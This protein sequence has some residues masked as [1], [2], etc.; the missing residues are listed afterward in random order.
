MCST[1]CSTCVWMESGIRNQESFIFRNQESFI[2]GAGR[3]LWGVVLRQV[4][5]GR[6]SQSFFS[7]SHGIESPFRG[8]DSIVKEAVPWRRNHQDQCIINHA[9]TQIGTLNCCVALKFDRHIGSTAA[10]V[11]VKFQSDRTILNTNLADSILYEILR[12][13][14]FSDIETG[15]WLLSRNCLSRDLE[16]ERHTENLDGGEFVRN[17]DL[18]LAEWQ[19]WGQPYL[20][21]EQDRCCLRHGSRRSRRP[22]ILHGSH[23][24][25]FLTAGCVTRVWVKD[26]T[27]CGTAAEHQRMTK[28]GSFEP[29]SWTP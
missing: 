17:G 11:P 26:G 6:F 3:F 19:S 2:I 23:C 15:P 29:S 18:V 8:P 27:G 24:R 14:V 22:C 1:V 21:L 12:K 20:A 9:T 13:D 5:H 7:S 16:R 25:C 10:E 28:S 4:D